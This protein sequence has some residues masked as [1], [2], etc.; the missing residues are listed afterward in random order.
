MKRN[1]EVNL[2]G[3]LAPEKVGITNPDQ[4]GNKKNVV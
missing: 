4:R 1:G 3:G 2:S